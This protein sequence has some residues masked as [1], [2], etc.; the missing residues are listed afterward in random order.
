MVRSEAITSSRDDAEGVAGVDSQ[1]SVATVVEVARKNIDVFA[2]EFAGEPP[3]VRI[4]FEAKQRVVVDCPPS[5]EENANWP[6]WIV[7]ALVESVVMSPYRQVGARLW[8]AF[9]RQVVVEDG[10]QI[11]ILVG[12]KVP[13]AAV[14]GVELYPAARI[15][16]NV[17]Q[18]V[19]AGQLPLKRLV[20]R[21][22]SS[23]LDLDGNHRP[24]ASLNAER[25]AVFVGSLLLLLEDISFP[26]P[27]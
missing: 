8:I 2:R 6:G 24:S 27:M 14:H 15:A 1:L 20:L 12:E 3:G 4:A 19:V 23:G 9:D 26:V 25:A 13:S 18:L 7:W 22:S 10:R 11:G 17:A 21:A 5:L 16:E